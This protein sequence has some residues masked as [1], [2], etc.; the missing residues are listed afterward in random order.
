MKPPEYGLE[1]L[2]AMSTSFMEHSTVLGKVAN[3]LEEAVASMLNEGK[4]RK[5]WRLRLA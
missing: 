1:A 5:K 3:I 2:L 4:R